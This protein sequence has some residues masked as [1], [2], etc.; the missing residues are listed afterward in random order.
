[1]ANPVGIQEYREIM[2]SLRK[3]TEIFHPEFEFQAI[4][5]SRALSLPFLF[6][7]YMQSNM[8]CFTLSPS[9]H[10]V[11]GCLLKKKNKRVISVKFLT[12][13]EWSIDLVFDSQ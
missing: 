7:F 8:A 12:S 5:I 2:C 11:C 6:L 3:R 9:F 13:D 1:V 10:Y 4:S